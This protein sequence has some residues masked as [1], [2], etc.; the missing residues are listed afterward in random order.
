MSF[1]NRFWFGL[2][3][4]WLGIALSGCL[5]SD[6]DQ[7]DEEKEPHFVLGKSRINTMDYQGA[8]E[9][10]EESLEVN[11][12]SAAAHFE[13][14][15]LYDEKESDPAAAI[16][17]YQQY[18]KFNPGAGNTEVIKQRIES[19]KQELAA[20]VLPLPSTPA[21][22]KQ[23]TQLIEQNQQLQDEVNKW[24]AYFAS[25]PAA[26][27]QPA[28]D[29]NSVITQS[30]VNSGSPPPVPN[31]SLMAGGSS[32]NHP[33]SSAPTKPILGTH[34]V[35]AGE[36]AVRIARRYGITLNAL[37]AANPGLEPRRM[38]VGQVLNI[39]SS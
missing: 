31:V 22:Q 30:S 20:D 25:Q 26:K 12:H 1:G 24:R 18:L 38:R 33:V 19:C 17:H 37:L 27:N 21:A 29:S 4:L 35:V 34:T 11:P 23:I 39:P 16:Y 28:T 8:V 7:S 13:L 5:P 14:G 36:T 3:A 2:F 32:P 6:Q 9:A 15:W 10:F